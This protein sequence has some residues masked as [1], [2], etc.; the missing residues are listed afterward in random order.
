MEKLLS[1]RPEN[2]ALRLF[3][4]EIYR[5]AGRLDQAESLYRACLARKPDLPA[6]GPLADIYRKR[7]QYGKL[8]DVLG[9]AVGRHG[10]LEPLGEPAKALLGDQAAVRAVV[11]EARRRLA[12]KGQAPTS[13]QL[14]AAGL[15]AAEARQWDDAEVLFDHAAGARPQRAADILLT[16]GLGLILDEKYARAVPVLR[17]GTD[18]KVARELAPAFYFYLAGALEMTGKTEEALAAAQR[19]IELARSRDAAEAAKHREFRPAWGETPRFELRRA[20]ILSHAKR[21]R[22]ATQAYEELV[23]K[24]DGEHGW[25]PLRLVLRDARLA[26]SNLA[27]LQGDLPAAEEWLEQVLDE[28]PDDASALNDL[29]YLWADAGKHLARAERMIRRALEQEPGNAAFRDSLGWVLF[30]QG[31]VEEALPELEKA[32]ADEPDPTV[33]DHLGDAYWKLGRTQEAR[34]AWQRAVKAHRQAGEA[35]KAAPIERKLQAPS[36]PAGGATNLRSPNAG[37]V[38]ASYGRS[39]ALGRHQAQE[40]LD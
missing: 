15:L 33:L 30:R 27:V 26:L 1:D 13:E 32:A 39:F 22:E 28:F 40:G 29:G 3:L 25:R 24:Y 6:L 12:H 38:R 8:L 18:S 35:A 2:L 16:W 9:E 19:A 21:Y 11:G 34:S 23:R 4:A 31:R 5:Q 37:Y 10:S 7:Q 14:L 36:L 20:W 17:R